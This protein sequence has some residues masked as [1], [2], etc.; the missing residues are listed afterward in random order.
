MTMGVGGERQAGSRSWKRGNNNEAY[1]TAK[2]HTGGRLNIF[3]LG[4][5]VF[6]RNRNRCDRK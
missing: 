2:E 4:G 5:K 3:V 1:K 6:N